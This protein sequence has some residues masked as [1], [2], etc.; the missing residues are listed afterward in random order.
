VPFGL[1]FVAPSESCTADASPSEQM[2]VTQLQRLRTLYE[3]TV[4]MLLAL[5]RMQPLQRY[6]E[7]ESLVM[8]AEWQPEQIFERI[9]GRR[10]IDVKR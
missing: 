10:L 2:W 4:Q 9:R 7:I 6:A 1:I 3:D 8:R 5:Q